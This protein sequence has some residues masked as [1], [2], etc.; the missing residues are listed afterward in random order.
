MH[1]Q[2]PA[3]TVFP[4]SKA[5]VVSRTATATSC[6]LQKLCIRHM[7]YTYG[8]C[9]AVV[10]SKPSCGLTCRAGQPCMWTACTRD[11]I[12]SVSF[13]IRPSQRQP[14]M[15]GFTELRNTCKLVWPVTL[16]PLPDYPLLHLE[17]AWGRTGGSSR[18]FARRGVCLSKGARML[19]HGLNCLRVALP[20]D[21]PCAQRS[22]HPR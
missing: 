1:R 18:R 14:L 4:T 6:L 11:L 12:H 5:C 10:K 21:G 15:I 17:T 19:E 8:I 22:G 2:H 7:S 13:G 3:D 16:V 20:Q 9:K